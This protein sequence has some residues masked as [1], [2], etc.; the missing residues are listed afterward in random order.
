MNVLDPKK[1]RHLYFLFS[2]GHGVR[3]AAR[4]IGVCRQTAGTYRRKWLEHRPT[5]QRA[6]DALWAGQC[7]ECD[8]INEPLPEPMV[9][10]MLDAW[11]EDYV[12]DKPGLIRSGFYSGYEDPPQA[13]EATAAEHEAAQQGQVQ[14]QPQQPSRSDGEGPCEADALKSAP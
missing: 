5:L 3:A 13:T 6:Y 10:A 11:S 9:L 7:E 2:Y 1:A 4:Q 12:D 8:R 14:D